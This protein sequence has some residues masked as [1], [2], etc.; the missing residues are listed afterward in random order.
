VTGW[1]D[2]YTL[3]TCRDLLFH[4]REHCFTPSGLHTLVAGAG[5]RFLGFRALEPG[6][7]QAYRRRF[8]QDPHGVDLALWDE[9]EVDHPQTFVAMY[10]FWV[11]TE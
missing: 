5:L 6:V 1:R 10:K 4:V 11:T 7:L 9:F 3:S 8:P 2:F